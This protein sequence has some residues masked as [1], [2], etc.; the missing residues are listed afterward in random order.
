VAFVQAAAGPLSFS[1]RVSSEKNYDELRF[2]VDDVE[3]GRWSGEAGWATF[4]VDLDAGT[5]TVRWRYVKDGTFDEGE[6]L[7]WIDDVFFPENAVFTGVE[8][9]DDLP[10]SYELFQNYPNPFSPSTSIV[11]TLPE[12]AQVSLVVYDALGRRVMVLSDGLQGRGRYVLPF[13]GVGLSNGIYYYELRAGSYT[14]RRAMVLL[15]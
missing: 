7:A 12:P 1:Y 9:Q 6:D 10:L 15:R 14:A 5:H 4:S 11:Y 3:Q 8:G 13:S 2:L